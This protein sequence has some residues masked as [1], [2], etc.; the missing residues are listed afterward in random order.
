MMH[1]NLLSSEIN[2]HPIYEQIAL[3]SAICRALP[4]NAHIIMENL[5]QS[6]MATL[7]DA[8]GMSFDMVVS[9]AVLARYGFQLIDMLHQIDMPFTCLSSVTSSL[10][11]S[12]PVEA[13]YSGL[14][15]GSETVNMETI[16]QAFLGLRRITWIALE[17]VTIEYLHG[18]NACISEYRPLLSFSMVDKSELFQWC[19]LHQYVAVSSELQELT[20]NC[21]YSGKVY[22]FPEVS[23][24]NSVRAL[25]ASGMQT[26]A[27]SHLSRNNLALRWPFL[28]VENDKLAHKTKLFLT[29]HT[30][31]Y[32][33]TSMLAK[34]LY[35]SE[36]HDDVVWRWTGPAN[37]SRI[38]LPMRAKGDYRVGLTVYALPQ[39]IET[40]QVRCFM[41]GRLCHEQTV[42]AGSKIEF[43]YLCD[44]PALPVELLITTAE[45]QNCGGRNLGIAIS[46]IRVNWGVV[47]D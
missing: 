1:E 38:L 5:P 40:S 26:E 7:V 15:R 25:M 36:C 32:P 3:T 47:N 42:A 12:A 30:R 18:A 6:I 34:G 46:G 10:S 28:C 44:S 21:Q 2:I 31:H 45:I 14:S 9:E 29:S 16:D 22:L 20:E 23:L 41:N 33:L 37:E 11:I 17:K 19:E 27:A 4:H 35:E 24:L 13:G 43:D 39:D 8:A